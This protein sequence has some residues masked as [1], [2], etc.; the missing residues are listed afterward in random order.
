MFC[1]FYFIKISKFALPG[2]ML[3]Y[4]RTSEDRKKERERKLERFIDIRMK[5]FSKCEHFF[6]GIMDLMLNDFELR[7]IQILKIADL[8]LLL[9]I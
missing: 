2:V 1:V 9:H 3:I 6:I 5:E 7:Q 8:V 4:E